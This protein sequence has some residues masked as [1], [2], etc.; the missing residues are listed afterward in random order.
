MIFHSSLGPYLRKK[1]RNGGISGFLKHNSQSFTSLL[2]DGLFRNE[3]IFTIDPADAR[4]LDDAVC[5]RFLRLADD[6]VTRLY[7][8]SVHIADVSFFVKENTLLDCIASQRATST[9]LVDRVSTE[10]PSGLKS[11]LFI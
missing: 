3:C 1:L 5:G 2:T 10:M 6:G 11:N 9:Y 4:D 7:Q 8:V